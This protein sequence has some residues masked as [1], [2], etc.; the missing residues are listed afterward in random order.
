M[1]SVDGIRRA[2]H[3]IYFLTEQIGLSVV[4]IAIRVCYRFDDPTV[5]DHP[6]DTP[7]RIRPP[8]KTIHPELVTGIGVIKNDEFV[9]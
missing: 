8:G 2:I 7:H 6:R 1:R 5:I 3:A 4:Y 9:G